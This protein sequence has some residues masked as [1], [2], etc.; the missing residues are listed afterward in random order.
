MA[1]SK[2]RELLLEAGARLGTRDAHH[3]GTPL[4][5]AMVAGQTGMQTYLA[6]RE[7]GIFDAVL[8]DDAGRVAE[9]LDGDPELLEKTIRDELAHGQRDVD[10]WQTPLAFA[11]LRSRTAAARLLLLERGARRDL[12]DGVGRSLTEIAIESA[13]PEIAALLRTS[14]QGSWD[15]GH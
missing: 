5:W 10:D 7:T 8:C 11:V 13:S 2:W 1:T 6:S 4:Q 12:R 3:A 15:S 9:L 14:R